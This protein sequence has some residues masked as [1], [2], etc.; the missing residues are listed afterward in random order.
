MIPP[1]LTPFPHCP[2]EVERLR[3]GPSTGKA[4]Q[5]AKDRLALRDAP[6]LYRLPLKFTEFNI[7]RPVAQLE[8]QM[9]EEFHGV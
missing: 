4:M 9:M 6:V 7:V 3:G 8:T 5:E 2:V 1:S